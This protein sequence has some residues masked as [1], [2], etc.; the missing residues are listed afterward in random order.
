MLSGEPHSL[1]NLDQRDTINQLTAGGIPYG[2]WEV[3]GSYSYLA[4]W[5]W[6]YNKRNCM[7]S[8][9]IDTLESGEGISYTIRDS[10]SGNVL[11]TETKHCARCFRN[12][13][14]EVIEQ[15]R[16]SDSLS[17]NDIGQCIVR[18]LGRQI[19]MSEELYKPNGKIW[20]KYKRSDTLINDIRIHLKV[21]KEYYTNT[22][23]SI[24]KNER[25]S[26]EYGC[27]YTKRYNR[28]GLLRK[29]DGKEELCREEYLNIDS[30]TVRL[31]RKKSVPHRD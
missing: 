28:N 25:V 5:R 6:P 30:D 7:L 2:Y 26:T 1:V 31:K 18:V 14:K 29:I 9:Y 13:L 15:K 20:R 21:Y 12:E 19:S 4:G 16:I 23:A 3:K 10:K 8:L 17:G 22:R 24:V 27:R 11:L